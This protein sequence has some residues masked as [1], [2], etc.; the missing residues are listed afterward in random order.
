[1]VGGDAAQAGAVAGGVFVEFLE[2]EE[3]FRGG[4]GLKGGRGTLSCIWRGGGC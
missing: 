4:G 3:K 2:S 1:M